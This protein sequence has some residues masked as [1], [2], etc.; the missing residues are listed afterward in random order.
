MARRKHVIPHCR[1][2]V[3]IREAT[4]LQAELFLPRDLITGKVK[5]GAWSD[6][7]QRLIDADL[8]KKGGQDGR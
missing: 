1:L 7:V 3:S 4:R 6:Y 5:L 8:A 2:E